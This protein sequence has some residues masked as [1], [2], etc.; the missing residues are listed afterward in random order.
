MGVYY[1]TNKRKTV[2]F[3]SQKKGSLMSGVFSHQK[4]KEMKSD[5]HRVGKK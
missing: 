1:P 4:G 5:E 3:E 2:G